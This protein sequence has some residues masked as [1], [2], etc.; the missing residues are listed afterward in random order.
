MSSCP[1]GSCTS[2]ARSRRM[3]LL[4]CP[5]IHHVNVR[6][7]PDVICQ[8]P[9]DVVR[10]VVNHD[11]V[12]IPEPV[13]AEAKVIRGNAKKEAAKPKAAR[14]ASDDPPDV[15]SADATWKMSV[16]PGMIEMVMGI[17]AAGIVA[18]PVVTLDL[19]VRCVWVSGFLV[20]AA[21]RCGWNRLSLIGTRAMSGN[22]AATNLRVAASLLRKSR[23][24]QYE[25]CH[26]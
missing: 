19:D 26:E 2:A 14:A 23:K 4:A 20:V 18:D 1:A 11:L 9:A 16:L 22:V 25:H 13:V 3:H 24:R 10:V 17:I 6:A 8:I 12:G 7:E 5:E 15:A 21:V